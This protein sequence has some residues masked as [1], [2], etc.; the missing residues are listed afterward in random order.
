ML[1]QAL[2]APLPY[3]EL[4]PENPAIEAQKK[5]LRARIRQQR[6][7]LTTRQQKQASR[8]LLKQLHRSRLLLRHKHIALYLG[9]DGE[10]NPEHLIPILW[11]RKKK[12]YL[13]VLH[14]LLKHQLCFCAFNKHTPLRQN[15]FG[16]KEPDFRRSKRLGRQ[17]LSLVMLPLVAFDRQGNRM[18]MGGGFY[19]RSFA[20]K[21]Q[22]ATSKPKLIGL[23]HSFQAQRELPIEEWDVPLDGILT[24]TSIYQF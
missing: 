4:K 24:D 10:L 15:R 19:D 3:E 16:I 11:A 23:A 7:A 14:P 20:Y 9:N 18:G 12:L 13:P 1:K 6:K 22:Q 8:N 2:D 21:H 5:A 17:F